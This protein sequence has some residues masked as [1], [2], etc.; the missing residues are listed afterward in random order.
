[1]YFLPYIAINAVLSTLLVL[2]VLIPLH[3]RAR[4]QGATKRHTFGLYAYTVAVVA[5]LQIT[6]VPDILHLTVDTHHNFTPFDIWPQMSMQYILNA[7]LFVPI[8]V[9]LPM[10]WKRFRN[11]VKVIAA[12]ALFSLLI[13]LSQCFNFRATDIDDL[14]MNTLGTAVGCLLFYALRFII[15][16]LKGFRDPEKTPQQYQV[17]VLWLAAWT[18]MFCVQPFVNRVLW[19]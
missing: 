16:P 7:M 13:E 4:R 17:V 19:G 1:M 9:T 18:V 15:P 5:I 14:M 6:G 10:L 12:G 2:P 11:P 8:G 3:I